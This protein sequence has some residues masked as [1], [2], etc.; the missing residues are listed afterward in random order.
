M[1]DLTHEPDLHALAQKALAAYNASLVDSAQ[2][3]A[4]QDLD[5]S[6]QLAWMAVAE[7]LSAP[8]QDLPAELF[9]GPGVY[10][11]L[12][13]DAQRRTSAENVSDVLDAVVRLMN[14]AKAAP[15]V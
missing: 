15:P 4:W 5:I 3:P 7:A 1:S 8:T 9:D 6:R 13:P 2:E 11:M 14:R 12:K 10:R